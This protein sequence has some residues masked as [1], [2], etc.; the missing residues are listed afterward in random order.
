MIDLTV[1]DE[2][3][4]GFHTQQI[5]EIGVHLD[6]W[7][8]Y[9]TMGPKPT[10]SFGEPSDALAARKAHFGSSHRARWFGRRTLRSCTTHVRGPRTQ[11]RK[12]SQDPPPEIDHRSRSMAPRPRPFQRPS[13]RRALPCFRIRP[14]AA[15]RGHGRELLV[16]EGQQ[17]SAACAAVERVRLRSHEIR[18]A[19]DTDVERT[20]RRLR[21]TGRG[22]WQEPRASACSRG[23]RCA[24]SRS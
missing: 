8:L 13:R 19:A 3:L 6:G 5:Q 18:A 7:R 12:A 21:A 4:F 15:I 16:L 24:I 22:A 10:G 14:P 9:E 2:E 23:R 1:P 20:F 17:G 11:L